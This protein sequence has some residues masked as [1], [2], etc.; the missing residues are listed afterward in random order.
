MRLGN[1]QFAGAGSV[2]RGIRKDESA[3]L[4][5]TAF[6]RRPDLYGH[7]RQ[8]LAEW[9]GY[10]RTAFDARLCFIDMDQEPIRRPRPTNR[11]SAG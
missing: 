7:D 10:D 9:M 6:G 1:Y 3:Y 11:I 5:D 2:A 8:G 4:N